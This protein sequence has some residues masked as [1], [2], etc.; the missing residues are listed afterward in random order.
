MDLPAR[1]SALRAFNRFWTARIGALDAH[2]LDT[3]YS[4]AEARVLF[5]LAHA[6]SVAVGQLRE[7]L[8]ID[9]GY[10]SRILA[11][12]A[13]GGV[14]A[15]ARAPDDARRQIAKLTSRGRSAFRTLDRRAA[16]DVTELLAA[17]PDAAQERTIAAMA[18][19]RRA[20]G[21][22]TAAPALVLRAP[23]AGDLGWIVERHGALY[24]REH[25]W[26]VEFEALVAR[27]VA[28]FGAR[29]DSRREAAWI[30]E[31]D[32][33]RVGCVMCVRKSAR[34]AQLRLLLVEPSARG[35]GI[36]ARLVA[37][38]VRFARDRGYQRIVLWTNDVLHSARRIYTAAGFA[39]VASG[40]HTAFGHELVEQTWELA[41]RE[42]RT[43]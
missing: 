14:V 1:V 25:G 9:A 37:E 33:E 12:L 24:A 13:R 40:P 3:P 42:P 27:I 2:L 31:L 5:E 28:E 32:G 15:L 20:L 43:G 10:L 38:C 35:H 39:L 16:A 6:P 36:G 34:V 7:Q 29:R 23:G 21:E 17:R 18:E 11:R 26:D 22:P 8:R 4:L 41:L 19:I 30:A